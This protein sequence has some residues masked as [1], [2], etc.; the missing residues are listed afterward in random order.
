MKPILES[1]VAHGSETENNIFTT[2]HANGITILEYFGN[3]LVS[4]S[5]T[6]FDAPRTLVDSLYQR[7][8]YVPAERVVPYQ[9]RYRQAVKLLLAF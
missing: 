6:E 2:A 9:G 1:G 5:D 8:L 3:R 4:W 7:A